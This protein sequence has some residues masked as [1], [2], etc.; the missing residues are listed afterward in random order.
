MTDVLTHSTFV[1]PKIKKDKWENIFNSLLNNY[2]EE[3]VEELIQDSKYWKTCINDTY[4]NLSKPLT[5]VHSVSKNKAVLQIINNEYDVKYFIYKNRK[6]VIVSTNSYTYVIDETNKSKIYHKLNPEFKNLDTDYWTCICNDYVKF[7][8]NKPKKYLSVIRGNHQSYPIHW[9]YEY[10]MTLEEFMNVDRLLNL[11]YLNINSPPLNLRITPIYKASRND[12]SIHLIRDDKV[13]LKIEENIFGLFNNIITE[14]GLDKLKDIR[15]DLTSNRIF[16]NNE[17]NYEGEFPYESNGNTLVNKYLEHSYMDDDKYFEIHRYPK[18][19][20]TIKHR[21]ELFNSI[22]IKY[23]GKRLF[24]MKFFKKLSRGNFLVPLITHY[25]YDIDIFNEYLQEEYTVV[26]YI[27]SE[28]VLHPMNVINANS[29]HTPFIWQN[30]LGTYVPDLD[31]FDDSGHPDTFD[32]DELPVRVQNILSAYG[33]RATFAPHLS[34]INYQFIPEELGTGSSKMNV[35]YSALPTEE[36]KEMKEVTNIKV[37]Y[38]N[39]E[40]ITTNKDSQLVSVS[41]KT[42][43]ERKL[44][45]GYKHAKISPNGDE[46]CLL[47]LDIPE[48]AK[49]ISHPEK[50]RTNKCTV[51]SILTL[52]EKP[53]D[54][55]AAF[56]AYIDGFTYHLGQ[57][58]VIEDYNSSDVVCVKG[59]HFCHSLDELRKRKW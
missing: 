39:D 35:E 8:Y 18:L 54:L 47:V 2:S 49:V 29:P 17:F 5:Y 33:I 30:I 45:T 12:D 14:E 27:V 11:D 55:V 13:L 4:A 52:D 28:L 20:I 43:E 32:Q 9:V 25:W 23:N 38:A 50:S 10:E 26:Q 44:K 1:L 40:I 37:D 21:E 15:I 7:Y 48:D 57:E 58:I 51:R 56:G 59:I 31:L 19:D 16:I 34:Q 41:V 6:I 42:G 22:L 53:T 36:P 3:Q 24:R 46:K